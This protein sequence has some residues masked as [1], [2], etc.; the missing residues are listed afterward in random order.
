MAASVAPRLETVAPHSCSPGHPVGRIQKYLLLAELAEQ[1]RQLQTDLS[2]AWLTVA[3]VYRGD[4][5]NCNAHVLATY[6]VL[7]CHPDEVWPTIVNNRRAKLA[8]EF[9]AWYEAN[10]MPKQKRLDIP[11]YD[12]TCGPLAPVWL[13]RL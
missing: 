4:A 2:I 7:G 13:G 10:G 3:L 5:T 6:R 11:D 1:D 12:P 9:D 8:K